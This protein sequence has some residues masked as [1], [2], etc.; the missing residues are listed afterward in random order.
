MQDQRRGSKIICVTDLPAL[1]A[2]LFCRDSPSLVSEH[3]PRIMNGGI[4]SGSIIYQPGPM[5][6]DLTYTYSKEVNV[7]IMGQGPS[8]DGEMAIV[9]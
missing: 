7:C 2:D 9:A 4:Q 8:A 1:Q 6:R 3:F 5:A